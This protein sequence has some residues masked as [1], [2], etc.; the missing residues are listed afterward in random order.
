MYYIR[1]RKGAK[2]GQETNHTFAVEDQD[3]ARRIYER[4]GDWLADLE[5]NGTL[6]WFA[7]G[8]TYAK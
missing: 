1:V 4:F 7:V 2:D 3:S 5:D 6:E 8:L